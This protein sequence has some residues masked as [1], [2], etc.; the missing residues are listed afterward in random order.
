M[1]QVVEHLPSKCKP[2]S[3]KPQYCN[4]QNNQ[5]NQTNLPKQNK[6]KKTKP[7]LNWVWWPAPVTLALETEA[8]ETL[9][10]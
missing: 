5:P 2:L 10:T 7:K 6:T 9:Q 8:E 3:S 1:A 4:K